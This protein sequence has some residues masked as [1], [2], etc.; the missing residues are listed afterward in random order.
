MIGAG[1]A[2]TGLAAF[3]TDAAFYLGLFALTHALKADGASSRGVALV[4]GIYTLAY[5]AAAPALGRTSDRR[6]DLSVLLGAGLFASVFSALSLALTLE[7]RDGVLRVSA[8]VGE[9]RALVYLAMTVLA[10]ANAMFWPALQARIGDRVSD[11]D[12]L[13]RAMRTFNVA[14]TSGKALGFLAG[15]LLFRL[16]PGVALAT[17]AGAGWLIVLAL[18][19]DRG[20]AGAAPR[21]D[22]G[23][24]ARMPVAQPRKRAFLLAAL[25]A[26][27][28]LWGATSTLA[29]LAP[30]LAE[31]WGISVPETGVLLFLST[32]AQGV[33]FVWLGSGR[34][35]AYRPGLLAAAVPCAALGLLGLATSGLVVA[36]L[37]AVMVGVA[38]AVTYAASVFYSL[39][40]DERRGLRTGIHEAVL[41]AGGALPILGGQIADSTGQVMAP[42]WLLL[43]IAAPLG[44]LLALVL[45]RAPPGDRPAGAPP[46]PA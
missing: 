46:D 29:G 45:L 31:G 24:A 12:A 21:E 17:V 36:L 35:W 2:L 30:K 19:L 10:A 4:V 34:R 27:F 18:V 14:W 8:R 15:G 37:G 3:L 44:L 43:G 38:Q 1:I 25:L 13:A 5:A 26:N 9:A 32:A 22:R 40:H 7:L 39:D 6:R 42:V 16:A 41:A 20:A 11:P 33:A 28:T 23:P